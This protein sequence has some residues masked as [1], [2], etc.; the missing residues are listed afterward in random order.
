M[1]GVAACGSCGLPYRLYH[2]E[3]EG[4]DQK[5]VEKPPSIAVKES[6]L[7]LARR[8]WIETHQRTFPAAFDFMSGRGGRTYSGASR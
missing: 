5:R 6:W 8:Y 1:A 2:Y 4:D 3:G 7:P